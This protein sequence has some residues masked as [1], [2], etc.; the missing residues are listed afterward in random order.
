MNCMKLRIT[1]FILLLSVLFM[2]PDKGIVLIKKGAC[3]AL[4]WFLLCFYQV[5]SG[6]LSLITKSSFGS[7]NLPVLS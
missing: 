6:L 2:F 4:K 1:S 7:I 5:I 3:S